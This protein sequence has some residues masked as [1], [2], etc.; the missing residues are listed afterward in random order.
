MSFFKIEKHNQIAILTLNRPE[1]MNAISLN[2]FGQLAQN[3]YNLG[4][5]ET[6]RA[7]ILTGEGHAFCAGAKLDSLFDDND[8]I[9]DASQLK[10]NFD[11]DANLLIRNMMDCPK[12]IVTAINGHAAGGGLGIALAGD[13]IL[14]VEDAKFHCGFVPMLGLVPDC[15]MSWF[16]PN[17][18]G[19]NKALSMALLNE[20]LTAKEASELGL[21]FKL[22]QSKN[23]MEEAIAV[24]QKLANGPAKAIVKTRKLFNNAGQMKISEML[25][26]ER[27][28]NCELVKTAELKE[29]INAFLEKRKPN[30]ISL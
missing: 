1:A 6:I 11:E 14:A 16:L 26:N 22:T 25:D 2:E 13:V 30:F 4:Q 17:L 5:D 29:G 7:I 19:R 9:I 12:P 20:P 23:L 8:N 18:L 24:A 21:I 15:G 3:I 10:Q 28:A 27:D